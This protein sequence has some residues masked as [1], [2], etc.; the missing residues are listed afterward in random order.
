MTIQDMGEATQ[1]QSQQR[2]NGRRYQQID[3]RS[4]IFPNDEQEQ[5][6]LDMLHHIYR[7]VL[8]GRLHVAPIGNPQRVLDIGTGTGL[9]ALDFAEYASCAFLRVDMSPIQ[10]QMVA[11]N[12]S[13]MIDDL[14]QEWAYPSSRRFDYI[15]QRSMSGSIGDWSKMYKQALAHL[16][17]GGWLEVQEFEVW[18][19]SQLPGGLSPDSAIATWQKLIDDGSV[20]L[21]RRLNYAS[22]FKAHLEE[23]GFVDVRTQVIKTP[24]G[25]WPKDAK[26]RQIGLYLQAQMNEAVEAVTLGYLTRALGWSEAEVQIMLKNV[27]KEFN[28]RHRH[29]YTFCWFITGRKGTGPGDL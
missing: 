10:P 7:L 2:F 25:T 26:L 15:H 9:W 6:R 24:I 4:Y 27:R 13:F 28:D 19:Y 17:P 1:L 18:F 8:D 20:A 12:C 21:S 22:R 11:P 5:E 16:E 14:E 29:L 23:A 3:D